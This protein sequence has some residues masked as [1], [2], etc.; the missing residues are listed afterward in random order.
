MSK[1]HRVLLRKLITKDQ[2]DS[3]LNWPT[4]ENDTLNNSNIFISNP[5]HYPGAAPEYPFDGP[6]FD[7]DKSVVKRSIV[8]KPESFYRMSNLLG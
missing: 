2:S 4:L 5:F 6:L 1:K 7:Q 3:Q 8:G